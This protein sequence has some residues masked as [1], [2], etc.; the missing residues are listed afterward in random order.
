MLSQK[1]VANCAI[2]Q[3]TT[4]VAVKAEELLR[5]NTLTVEVTA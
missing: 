3:P 2:L 4:D 5:L 1:G